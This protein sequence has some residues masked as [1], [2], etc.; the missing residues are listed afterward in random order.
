MNIL[1]CI[2]FSWFLSYTYEIFLLEILIILISHGK[3]KIEMP[4][5]T[6]TNLIQIYIFYEIIQGQVFHHIHSQFICRAIQLTGSLTIATPLF[7][8]LN[9]CLP[10]LQTLSKQWIY[11]KSIKNITATKPK[12][13]LKLKILKERCV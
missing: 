9:I 5:V 3:K 13:S 6:D 7:D 4:H 2:S 1:L 8:G 10:L 12:S 11:L